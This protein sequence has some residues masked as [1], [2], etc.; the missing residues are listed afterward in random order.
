M[1]CHILSVRNILAE[2]ELIRMVQ[3]LILHYATHSEIPMLTFVIVTT[4]MEIVRP[5]FIS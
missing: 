5:D 3:K 1:L 4:K 2:L